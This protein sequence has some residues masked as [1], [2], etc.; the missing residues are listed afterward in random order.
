MDS[1]A[2]RSRRSSFSFLL[3]WLF[4]SGFGF[5][6]PA[7]AESIRLSQAAEDAQRSSGPPYFGFSVTGAGDVNGDGYDD[8]II[9]AWGDD[10]IYAYHG[11]ATG[12]PDI[13][14]WN[15][16]GQADSHFGWSIAAAGDVNDDGYDDVIVGAPFHTTGLGR[17]GSL[18]LFRGSPDG[19]TLSLVWAQESDQSNSDYGGS[20]SGAGDVNGDG[21]DD[22]IVGASS[23]DNGQDDEGRVFVYHGSEIGLGSS[24]AWDREGDAAARHLGQSVAGAGDVNN[25]TYDDVIIGA[26]GEFHVYFGS[27]S[28]LGTTRIRRSRSENGFGAVVSPAGDVNSDGYD[29]VIVGAGDASKAF[30]YYGPTLGFPDADW[31]AQEDGFFGDSVSRAGDLDGDGYDDVLVGAPYYPFGDSGRVFA[32]KGSAAGLATTPSWTIVNTE[33]WLKFGVAVAGAGDVNHDT[34][35]DVIVGTDPSTT[36]GFSTQE[37]ANLYYGSADGPSTEADW[38]KYGI[39]P[40]PAG[41][42]ENT[43]SIRRHGSGTNI[44]LTWGN[45]QCGSGLEFEVY[46]GHLGDFSSHVPKTC[47]SFSFAG[48]D[49]VLSPNPESSYYLVV[50]HDGPREGSYGTDG[51]G[52]ERPPSQTACR[53]PEIADCP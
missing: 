6:V 25:D 40:Q 8:L 5:G 22:V 32:Y 7:A 39:P 30:A 1:P 15:A 19:L 18:T 12:L 53:P 42:V 33:Q 4:L 35:D 17:V 51:G 31:T 13:A 28:G 11:S 21:Y 2:A 46:E 20:V 43:L 50:V 10:T 44:I 38:T 9:G 26:E 16:S 52:N 49:Y 24:F 37:R 29:D 48:D 36:G 47:N 27:N 3:A 14:D 34:F 45:I 23:Y 41:S